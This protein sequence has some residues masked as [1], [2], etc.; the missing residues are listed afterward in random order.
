MFVT[1]D[2]EVIFKKMFIGMC[3]MC[4]H[5]KFHKPKLNGALVI[6]VKQ[7]AGHIFEAASTLLPYFYRNKTL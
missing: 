7:K 4:A 5:A 1:V 6:S 2:L 3:M